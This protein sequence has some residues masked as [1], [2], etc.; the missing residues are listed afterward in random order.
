MKQDRN[1][2]GRGV[3]GGVSTC[4]VGRDFGTETICVR[5][6][7]ALIDETNTGVDHVAQNGFSR[8]EFGEVY[9][10]RVGFSVGL[11]PWNFF[12]ERASRDASVPC[13]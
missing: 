13:L 8:V 2:R 12:T 10:S 4:T 5:V 11:R 3:S 1:R 7:V 6:H 9:Y